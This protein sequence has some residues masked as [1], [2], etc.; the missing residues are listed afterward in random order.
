[1]SLA[2]EA[3]HDIGQTLRLGEMVKGFY[4]ELIDDGLG[5]KDC[6]IISRLM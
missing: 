4:D 6:S 5:E 3:A 1:M 2:V